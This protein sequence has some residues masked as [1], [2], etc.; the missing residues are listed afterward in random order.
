L[1]VDN[2]K[3]HI[4]ELSDVAMSN[5]FPWYHHETSTRQGLPYLAHIAV[6]RENVNSEE[7]IITSPA[8]YTE[9]KRIF[10]LFCKAH[11]IEYTRIYRCC[12][13]MTYN[14]YN[15]QQTDPHVDHEIEHKL[16]LLYLNDC[17]GDTILY[18]EKY[19]L[20]YDKTVILPDDAVKVTENTRVSP[21]Y[22]KAFCTDGFTFHAHE[23]CK[24]MERRLTCIVTFK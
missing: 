22:G 1:I 20:D 15:V 10:D 6:P 21:E 3:E 2:L 19:S 5:K 23:F 12:L 14:F 11:E 4:A 18:N 8:V 24:P 17:S 7:Q 16:F 9:A 13:N